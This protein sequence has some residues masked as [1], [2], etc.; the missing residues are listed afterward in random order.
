MR[1]AILCV[2]LASLFLMP[3]IS[4]DPYA[5]IGQSEF[6]TYEGH[7][8]GY[9]SHFNDGIYE[10]DAYWSE[11]TSFEGNGSSMILIQSS[12]EG[13]PVVRIDDGAFSNDHVESVIIPHTVRD[14]MSGA[15]TGCT[16]LTDVYFLGDEPDR[17]DGSFPQGCTFH[18]VSG[19]GWSTVTDIITE[20]V[21]E[22]VRYITIDN[23]AYVTGSDGDVTEVR[24]PSSIGGIPVRSVLPWAFYESD[25]VSVT[26]SSESIEERAFMGCTDLVDLALSDDVRY[27][28]NEAFRKCTSMDSLDLKDVRYIGFESFRDCSSIPS[29]LIPESVTVLE[30]GSFYI[31]SSVVSVR[32]ESDIEV[33]LPRTFGYCS[34]LKD[35]DVGDIISIGASCFIN[36]TSLESFT[37]SDSVRIVG[38]QAFSG[39]RSLYDLTISSGIEHLG[40]SVFEGCRSLTEVRLGENLRS[41]G[42]YAFR[43]CLFLAK[44]YFEGEMPEMGNSVFYGTADGFTVVYASEHDGSWKD[45]DETR[46]QADGES[47]IDYL[48]VILCTMA[49]LVLSFTI[50]LVAR[51][52]INRR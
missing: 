52:Y 9:V 7:T 6:T 43:D 3:Y 51:R 10:D 30:E 46:K 23:L 8:Y 44:A 13:Y 37:M 36:D 20:R 41:V 18:S 29:I 32:I 42:D 33:L 40:M 31:C 21:H 27:I 2:L 14:I 48:F 45:Y 22:G 4:S 16:S 25:V 50:L 5:G 1:K 24:I 35:V 26:I 17:E 47:G 11:I 19:K 49:L 28:D 34:S 38:D 39:C 15:F 12:L